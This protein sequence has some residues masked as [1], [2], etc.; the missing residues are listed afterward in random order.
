MRDRSMGFLLVAGAHSG[1]AAGVVTD[2]D[3]AIRCCAENRR[4]DEISVAEIAT[5]EILTCDHN[6]SI[7]SAER[8]MTEAG[9][10][11]LVIVDEIGQAAGVLSLTD[12][13]FRDRAGRAVKTARGVLAREAE[14]AHQPVEGIKLTPSTPEDEEKAM[15]QPTAMHGGSHDAGGKIFPVG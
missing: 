6:E 1:K 7:Q 11:R 3:I 13:L 10:S 15:R 8:L 9:K 2:R 5:T 12:I 14:G 4:P